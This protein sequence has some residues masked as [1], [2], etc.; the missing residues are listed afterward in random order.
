MRPLLL[1]S[2]SFLL[3]LS[4]GHAPAPAQEHAPTV[5]AEGTL[6]GLILDPNEARIPGAQITVENKKYRVDVESNDEGAFEVQLPA[7]EY[8]L[9]IEFNGFRDYRKRVRIEADKTETISATLRPL[10]PAG[11]MKVK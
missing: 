2:V 3:L 8:Q 7:G 5:R 1:T 4:F 9:K 6:K 10:P 11:T